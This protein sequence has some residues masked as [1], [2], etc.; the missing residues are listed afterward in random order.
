MKF[1]SRSRARRGAVMLFF[2]LVSFTISVFSL[3]LIDAARV[4]TMQSDIQDTVVAAARAGTLELASGGTH[5]DAKALA[6]Q[7]LEARCSIDAGFNSVACV[8]PPAVSI[9]GN[10]VRVE[11]TGNMST[12]AI[13]LAGDV[14]NVRSLRSVTINSDGMNDA[15]SQS[16]LDSGCYVTR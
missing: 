1:R 11:V 14:L 8:N 5:S 2:I 16:N 13:G 10:T 3:A 9:T 6:R 12:W 4:R 15:C 7:V